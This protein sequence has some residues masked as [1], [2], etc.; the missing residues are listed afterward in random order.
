M[1]TAF[2]SHCHVFFMEYCMYLS[3]R[4]HVQVMIPISLI[5]I[6]LWELGFGK[7]LCTKSMGEECGW[8]CTFLCKLNYR[9]P[10]WFSFQNIY[11]FRNI[12]PIAIYCI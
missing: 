1:S 6:E 12:L 9:E 10:L 2:V 7:Y 11:S 3:T 8:Q 4:V 5:G